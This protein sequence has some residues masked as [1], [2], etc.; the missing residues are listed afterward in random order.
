[1]QWPDCG[2]AVTVTTSDFMTRVPSLILG[3]S[4]LW[5]FSCSAQ[6]VLNFRVDFP[7]APVPPTLSFPFGGAQLEN[8][9]FYAAVLLG[10]TPGSS[11]RIVERSQDGSFATVF[12]F[13][14]QV[15]AGY[16]PILGL[17]GDGGTY[18]SYEQTWQ[19]NQG[20]TENLLAGNWY[21]EVAINGNVHLGQIVTVPEPCV[22]A[23]SLSG[24]VLLIVRRRNAQ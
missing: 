4:L 7:G 10:E 19:V 6:G 14:N 20:Q 11:G 3:L 17:P 16:P 9:S 12:E 8:N 24:F 15:L 5:Q 21:A 23:L 18:Y 2:R 1:M 22:L 13:S